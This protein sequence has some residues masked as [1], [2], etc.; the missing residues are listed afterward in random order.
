MAAITRRTALLTIAT[1]LAISFSCTPR[2]STVTLTVS[3]MV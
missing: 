2:E 3:G 1:A